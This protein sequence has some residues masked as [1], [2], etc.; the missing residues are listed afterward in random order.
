M[1]FLIV[2]IAY[3]L[4]SVYAA[5]PDSKWNFE[6]GSAILFACM[7]LLPEYLTVGVFVYIG[8]RV[9]NSVNVYEERDDPPR[10]EDLDSEIVKRS[11]G[12]KMVY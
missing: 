5:G 8:L 12:V 2:R 3:A 1:S 4:I 7:A 10:Y 11:Y 6:T 9:S